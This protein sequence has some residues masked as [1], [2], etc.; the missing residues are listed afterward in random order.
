MQLK[1]F[2]KELNKCSKCGLCQ[3]VCPLYEISKNDCAVSKGKFVMLHGVV[4]GDLELS[5]NIDKYLNMCLR[6]G[7]CTNFCPSNID[8]CK[9][10]NVA[11]QD[12]MKNKF[13]SKILYFI[14]SRFVF[15]LIIDLLS[16]FTSFFRPKRYECKAPKTVVLYFKGCVNKIFP[17]TDRYINKILK[18]TDIKILEAN[19]DCCGLPFLSDG[20]IKRFEQCAKNNIKKF[21]CDYD[22]LVTDC[23]SCEST[24]LD[25]PK[26]FENCSINTEKFLNWGDLIAKENIKFVFKSPVKIT[27][28]KPCHLKS[29]AFFEKI[30]QNCENVQYIRSKGDDDCCGF[31]GSF[32][33]KQNKLSKLIMKKK[34]QNIID[35][36]AQYVVTT[37]PS[38]LL[39]LRCGLK[40]KNAKNT[41]VIGLLEFLSKADKII[42]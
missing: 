22:Y 38:C 23:A 36:G 15:L 37:C 19:F 28:H 2:E 6:C 27:F 20:N 24:I 31:A 33:L 32:A 21:D 12:Y 14:Q 41:K 1:D 39:G 18:N 25:Y 29:D 30:I 13:L 35:S 9:I 10:F 3:S 42:Y 34:A 16:F 8:A 5:K 7:K 26:Y 17:N 11:K 4:K 40:L